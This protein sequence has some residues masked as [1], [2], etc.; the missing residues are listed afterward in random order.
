V[1]V[2]NYAFAFNLEVNVLAAQRAEVVLHG[3]EVPSH[4]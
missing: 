1:I 3:G 4:P 2:V